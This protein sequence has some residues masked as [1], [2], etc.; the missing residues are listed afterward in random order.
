MNEKFPLVLD[1]N[2]I[3]YTHSIYG[4]HIFRKSIKLRYEI[5]DNLYD[6]YGIYLENYNLNPNQKPSVNESNAFKNF[7]LFNIKKNDDDDKIT[8]V[9]LNEYDHYESNDNDHERNVD[10]YEV[11]KQIKNNV[12]EKIKKF[13]ILLDWIKDSYSNKEMCSVIIG[14]NENRLK[15]IYICCSA[16][17]FRVMREKICTKEQRL[18]IEQMKSKFYKKS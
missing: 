18:K 13:P 6:N 3:V 16:R 17:Y 15:K 2:D 4:N 1:T 11:S 14:Y 10:Y 12:E 7:K 8:N 9:K 5:I